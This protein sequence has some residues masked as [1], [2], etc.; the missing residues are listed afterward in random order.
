MTD[1]PT[2]DG[3]TAL[4]IR[5]RVDDTL[6]PRWT[7]TKGA[8]D[9][10]R[11]I[12]WKDRAAL[13]LFRVGENPN[14]HLRW[15]R[16]SALAALTADEDEVDS[17]LVD[18]YRHAREAAF[19]APH[20]MLNE[21]AAAAYDH[22][23]AF[24]VPAGP[25]FQP[26][27]VP[28][29]IGGPT[30][31]AL[32]QNQIPLMSSGLG[33]RRLVALALQRAGVAGSSILLVDEVEHGLE[34][35]G[36]CT[37]CSRCERRLRKITGFKGWTDRPHDP[38]SRRDCGVARRRAHVV[39][40]AGGVTTIQRI[41]DAFADL[42]ETDP[43]A[44]ARAGAAALLARRVIVAEGR[45]EIGYFRAM[46]RC[47]G[48]EGSTGRSPRY[49]DYGR[50]RA[51]S[52]WSRDRGSLHSATRQHCSLIRTHHFIRQRQLLP[53]PAQELSG[54]MKE[55]RSRSVSRVISLRRDCSDSSNSRSSVRRPASG[56]GCDSSTVP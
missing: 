41:T 40:A 1:D 4:T 35:S 6:E 43:Q 28:D 11:P 16:G 38:R 14:S 25:G 7:V 12:G 39:R 45:T 33:T 42:A 53:P 54:G 15:G 46:A 48:R 36:C 50:R 17:T 18:A 37:Y 51:T 34:P 22:A 13:Q 55:C 31:L 47:E 32:H 8:N 52:P 27:L 49:D 3:E 10:G 21:A 26:G 5:L 20:V 29:A 19:A 24:G 44:I 23:V 30:R 2:P 56:V 9:E